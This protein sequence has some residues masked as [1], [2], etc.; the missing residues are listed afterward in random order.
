M[1]RRLY[2]LCIF[3]SILVINRVRYRPGNPSTVIQIQI[4]RKVEI[5]EVYISI[6]NILKK[7]RLHDTVLVG[8]FNSRIDSVLLIKWYCPVQFKI[9]SRRRACTISVPKYEGV[10]RKCAL[11]RFTVRSAFE[12]SVSIGIRFLENKVL[13]RNS[14]II[15]SIFINSAE[16]VKL[17][18]SRI[19]WS[20][21]LTAL[22]NL[23]EHQAVRSKISLIFG[24]QLGDCRRQLPP[25]SHVFWA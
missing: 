8:I 18:T 4:E 21:Y 24:F 14:Q 25:H 16:N 3:K 12:H 2:G 11:K 17:T 13:P 9:N 15:T 10:I 1:R 6:V 5:S 23:Y 19:C 20:E 7:D 22:H